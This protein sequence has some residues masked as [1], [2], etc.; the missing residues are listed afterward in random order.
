[1]TPPLVVTPTTPAAEPSLPVD[2]DLFLVAGPVRMS[3]A[4]LQAMATPVMT[5][6]SAEFKRHMF[7][8]HGGL[9]HAFG[10]Q[11]STATEPGTGAWWGPD[12]WGVVAVNGS[13]TAGV[14]M[15]LA[16]RFGPDDRVLVPTNGKFGE[17]VAEIAARFTNVT[18]IKGD[19]GQS[20]D[21][22]ELE[23]ALAAEP[24]TGLAICHN[25]TSTAITQDG[26]AL[27]ELAR[28]HGLAYIIDGITSVA[29]LPV[30]AAEWGAE[31]VITG[32]QKCT[33]GPSGVAAIAISAGY[34][35]AVKAA[36]S[37]GST[38]PLYYFDLLPAIKQ[39]ANDQCPWTAAINPI[40]G[41]V[42]ALNELREEGLEARWA[43]CAKLAAGLRVMFTEL[44]FEVYAEPGHESPTVTAIR[45]P[46]GVDDA[47]RSRLAKVY[48]TTVIGG[49]DA[50]KGRM[51]RVGSMGLVTREEMVEGARRMVACF[52]DVGV[53]L[54]ADVD[55]AAYF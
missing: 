36:R 7:H 4:T 28:R 35:D 6:R 15:A 54:P 24:H 25:E 30:H 22:R 17:R 11:P 38:P 1:M 21:Y 41:W 31:A 48:R 34:I 13:G 49:Q 8:L 20:F 52:R 45:Y 55:V 33:A 10:L 47:W 43:R 18:H 16:N 2:H 9:R 46:E 26:H 14:E 27:G 51:F 53:S 29:G 32:G 12:E 42:E 5:A 50:M 3:E 44:G 39:A 19:W 23:A 37:S 40:L